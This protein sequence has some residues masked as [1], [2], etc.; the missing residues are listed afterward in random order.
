MS[1]GLLQ[2]LLAGKSMVDF[3]RKMTT[4]VFHRLLIGAMLILQLLLPFKNYQSHPSS[5]RQ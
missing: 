2:L 3:G 4:R 5:A 1:S